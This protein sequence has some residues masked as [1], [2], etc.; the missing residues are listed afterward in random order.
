ML[1]SPAM[2]GSAVFFHPDGVGVSGWQALRYATV[3]PKGNI[4]WDRL[5]NLGVYV[6][7]MQDAAAATSNGAATTHAYGV[8]AK[9]D[10]Y[11]LI[12]KKPIKSASG[13]A[14]SILQEAIS[15]NIKTILINSGNITEPGTG[16]FVASVEQRSDFDNITEQVLKSGVD[17]I[18]SGGEQH[19]LPEGVMGRHGNGKRKDHKNLITEAQKAGYIVV[20][21]SEELARAAQQKPQKLLGVF[22]SN[23]S[24]NDLPELEL[25]QKNLPRYSATAPTIARMIENSLEIVKGHD[26]LMIAEEEATDN[27]ANVGNPDAV[28]EALQRADNALGVI[29]DF[30]NKNNSDLMLITLSDSD[31]GGMQVRSEKKGVKTLYNYK[32]SVGDIV[33]FSLVTAG[34]EDYAGGILARSTHK[35]PL[36]VDNTQIYQLLREQ[37]IND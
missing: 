11:G 8:Q 13:F 20:Y 26:F 30:K 24:F 35:L 3:G 7:S 18:L 17:I 12:D 6:G 16:A 14:G 22:A 27:F 5:N 21:N 9:T 15:K 1:V 25:K 36:L 2:A 31:A 33:N 4:N 34:K 29:L 37:V 23:H 28:I 10:S 19:M 32:N